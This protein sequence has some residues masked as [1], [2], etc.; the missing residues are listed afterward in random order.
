MMSL[1]RVTKPIQF[2]M[3]PHCVWER[4][5]GKDQFTSRR[6]KKDSQLVYHDY[7]ILRTLKK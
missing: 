3:L 6:R 2:Y 1:I 4:K 5:Y 7:S